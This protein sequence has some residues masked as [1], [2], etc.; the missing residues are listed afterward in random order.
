MSILHS[1]ISS[2]Q[3]NNIDTY[4]LDLKSPPKKYLDICLE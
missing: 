2:T 1:R 3:V 4:N